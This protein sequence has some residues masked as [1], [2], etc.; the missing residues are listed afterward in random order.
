VKAAPPSVLPPW[1]P[2]ELPLACR[3]EEARCAAAAAGRRLPTA[4]RPRPKPALEA[5]RQV[6]PIDAPCP[7]IP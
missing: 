3:A 2:A 1:I 5:L 7:P 6:G 4:Y